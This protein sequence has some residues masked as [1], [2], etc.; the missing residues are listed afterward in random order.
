MN[1]VSNTQ[2][3]TLTPVHAH[4]A[5]SLTPQSSIDRSINRSHQSAYCLPESGALSPLLVRRPFA[6]SVPSTPPCG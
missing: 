1:P 5:M 2:T 3:L 6:L 4:L